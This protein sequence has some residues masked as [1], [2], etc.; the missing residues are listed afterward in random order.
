MLL[1]TRNSVNELRNTTISQPYQRMYHLDLR[2]E[3]RLKQSLMH[4]LIISIY[5]GMFQLLYLYISDAPVQQMFR[6]L[7]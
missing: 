1:L 5:V 7:T 4:H 2:A 6:V 3:I